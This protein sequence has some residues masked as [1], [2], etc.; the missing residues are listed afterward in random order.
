MRFST[1][2]G[3]LKAL[4]DAISPFIP[5]FPSP[6]SHIYGMTSHREMATRSQGFQ[7]SADLRI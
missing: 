5:A 4:S 1:C 3:M 6:C 2:L 7:I